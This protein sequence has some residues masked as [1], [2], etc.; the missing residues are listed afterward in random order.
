MSAR[1]IRSIESHSLWQ[2]TRARYNF[3]SITSRPCCLKPSKRESRRGIFTHSKPANSGSGC[4]ERPGLRN[5]TLLSTSKATT[6]CNTIY[7]LGLGN[8]GKL[9]ADSLRGIPNPPSIKFLVHRQEH[10]E[11]WRKD[12]QK[13]EIITKGISQTRSGFV[14]ELIEEADEIILHLVISVKAQ[15]TVAALQT[16]AHR[17]TKDSTI[18]FLQNGMGILDEINDTVFKDEKMR[19]NYVPGIVTHGVHSA[20]AFGA[21][22]AGMGHIAL[23]FIPRSQPV[24]TN[25]RSTD[26]TSIALSTAYLLQTM[27]RTPVLA[28]VTLSIND[29]VQIQFEKL[30]INA[31][32]NPLTVMFRCRN[33][34][35]F[36]TQPVTKIMR[37]L[38]SEI[39]LVIRSLP[40]LQH[41]PSIQSRFAP[42]RLEA[43]ILCTI[44][45]TSANYSSML[46]DLRQGRD[47]EIDYINGYIVKRGEKLGILCALNCMLLRMI[48]GQSAILR[49]SLENEK[50]I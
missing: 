46:Q 23:A 48:Q 30:A 11:A 32:V 45:K 22:H 19:P 28:A 4:E 1:H 47:T 41:L 9:V 39:S 33:G 15:N 5:N 26:S 6:S 49:S 21:V 7:I 12:G 3:F 36:K 13:L 37:M 43:Q 16:I 27:A 40:E 35:L 18:V 20:S 25:L 17:L 2:S 42:E 29:F 8:I 14:L 44:E 31:I 10:V 34:E 24:D 50:Q 38:L